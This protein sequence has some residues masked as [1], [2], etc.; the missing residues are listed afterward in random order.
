[1]T[2]AL[3]ATFWNVAE[4]GD[5]TK[6]S[7]V[8]LTHVLN[9]AFDEPWDVIGLIAVRR[10]ARPALEAAAKQHHYE[11][12]AT[13]RAYW[14][15][16]GSRESHTVMLVRRDLHVLKTAAEQITEPRRIGREP[17][18]SARTR[19]Q[20][21]LGAA[22]VA[23]DAGDAAMAVVC[24]Y[25][26]YDKQI[27]LRGLPESSADFQCGPTNHPATPALGGFKDDICAEE[28]V[29]WANSFQHSAAA[30]GVIVGGDWNA[31]SDP[32][33]QDRRD[34]IAQSGTD[35]S[36]RAWTQLLQERVDPIPTYSYGHRD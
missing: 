32:A 12:V 14:D 30:D 9:Q 15:A 10:S 36:G 34:D 29:K 21:L 16:S 13:P 19:K 5:T 28:A 1:M 18:D 23:V 20:L 27:G 3:T 2:T 26:P 17:D 6:Q 4:L 31:L 33:F 7:H 11:V 35:A 24:I 8:R 22:G 25:T